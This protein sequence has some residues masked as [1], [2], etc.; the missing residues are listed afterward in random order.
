M[1]R[2]N[3]NVVFKQFFFLLRICWRNGAKISTKYKHRLDKRRT[4]FFLA[5]L[6]DFDPIFLQSFQPICF[7]SSHY[8]KAFFTY[9]FPLQL[10]NS[11]YFTHCEKF[12]LLLLLLLW[13]VFNP[14]K[15]HFFRWKIKS[16]QSELVFIQL[17]DTQ[18]KCSM[19]IFFAE[20]QLH[21]ILIWASNWIIITFENKKMVYVSK[22]DRTNNTHTLHNQINHCV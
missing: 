16:I 10:R 17:S 22:I 19:G 14:L 3:F 21:S 4:Q 8:L 12:L 15:M 5:F 6:R 13:N 20:N 18:K 1:I 7:F 2:A 11:E 9:K